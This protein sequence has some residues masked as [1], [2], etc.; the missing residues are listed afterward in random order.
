MVA[1]D[2]DVLVGDVE[3]GG[4]PVVGPSGGGAVRFVVGGA[5]A[6]V[7]P[8]DRTVGY[9]RTRH[10]GEGDPMTFRRATRPRRSHQQT[11]NSGQPRSG[12]S[13]RSTGQKARDDL[14]HRNRR[15]ND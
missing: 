13:S 4:G 15:T 1:A 6:D 7:I 2:G 10:L 14:H 5:G 9:R 8:P 11:A 3:R 12:T